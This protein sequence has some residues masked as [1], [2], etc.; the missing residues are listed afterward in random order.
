[1][2]R[3]R[4]KRKRSVTITMK[5]WQREPGVVPFALNEH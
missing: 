4:M 3:M 2:F 1:M 5:H